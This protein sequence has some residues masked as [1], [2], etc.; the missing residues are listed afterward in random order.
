MHPTTGSDGSAVWP[1][2]ETATVNTIS[3]IMNGH[4]LI[5]FAARRFIVKFTFRIKYSE[6]AI[7][8]SR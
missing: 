7:Q 1:I 6:I 2:K 8:M 4:R 5:D 3:G